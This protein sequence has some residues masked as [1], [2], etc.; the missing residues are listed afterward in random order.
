M[1]I[2]SGREKKQMENRSGATIAQIPEKIKVK[3]L[4]LHNS[5]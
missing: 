5:H 3:K 4:V 2:S 1:D